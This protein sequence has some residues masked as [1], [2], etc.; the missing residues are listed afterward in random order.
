MKQLRSP[1]VPAAFAG[2]LALALATGYGPS[3]GTRA[4]AQ[5][6]PPAPP[7]P[8]LTSVPTPAPAATA[9]AT[10]LPSGI[11]PVATPDL[12][13]PAPAPTATPSP[14]PAPRGR[15][16]RRSRPA[17][18]NANA[19]PTTPPAPTATP[20]S[21]AFATLDGTW[22]VQAQYIDHTDYS[23]FVIKQE[24]SGNLGGEWRVQKHVYP[25]TGTYDGR[26]IRFTAAEPSVKVVF[27]GYVEG[28][29]DM[30]GLIDFGVPKTDATP[31]TAEHRPSG[32]HGL[33]K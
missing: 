5:N 32:G 3:G 2:A 25:L 26:I 23:Y 16:G 18:A 10:A 29:Q 1:R 22:E 21:P 4:A 27:S 8:I 11:S 9:G 28:A 19:T 33:F 31:F 30:I 6:A 13:T 14:T 20:T 24:P 12:S 15:R 17:P 7:Q